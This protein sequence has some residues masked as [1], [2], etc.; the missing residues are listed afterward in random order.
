MKNSYSLPVM[1]T[2]MKGINEAPLFL[3]F[4]QFLYGASGVFQGLYVCFHCLPLGILW[5]ASLPFAFWGP[6]RAV[7]VMECF[8]LLM[9]FPIHLHLFLIM[10]VSKLSCLYLFIGSWLEMVRSQKICKILLRSLDWKADNLVVLHFLSLVLV[11]Y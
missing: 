7:L 2:G 1:P 9:V 6:V 5:P 4:R 8:S 10:M 11:L 3:C